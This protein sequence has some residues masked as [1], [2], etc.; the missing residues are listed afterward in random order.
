MV[1][2]QSTDPVNP[3][4]AS[5]REAW[6]DILNDSRKT[7][8]AGCWTVHWPCAM[9]RLTDEI[10]LLRA[11]LAIQAVNATAV[12]Q[13]QHE[14]DAA[15][16]DLVRLRAEL[17]EWIKANGPGGWIDV[18]RKR[19]GYDPVFAKRSAADVGEQP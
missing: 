13:A 10:E 6:G 19:A 14:R 7:H 15:I 11:D 17:L 8:F 5:I 3:V 16:E 1:D 18:L 9:A 12:L 4:V 2:A